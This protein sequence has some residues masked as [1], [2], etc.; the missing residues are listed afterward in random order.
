ML[1][2]SF[3]TESRKPH[4]KITRLVVHITGWLYL[5]VANSYAMNQDLL[6]GQS[7]FPRDFFYYF[8]F[9]GYPLVFTLLVATVQA[10]TDEQLANFNNKGKTS[11]DNCNNTCLVFIYVF[12]AP[13]Y[14]LFTPY[15]LYVNVVQARNTTA[16]LSSY[17]PV[18]LPSFLSIVVS[19]LMM[20]KAFY[21]QC[22][23]TFKRKD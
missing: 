1:H 20:I 9:Y 6:N 3:E 11:G 17:S 22:A 18:A 14:A 19:N 23:G 12:G 16:A 21:D 8:I 2:F 15:A 7:Y 13:F 5:L 4:G 10:R